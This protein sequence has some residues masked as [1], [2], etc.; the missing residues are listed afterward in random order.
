[1]TTSMGSG[2]IVDD[3]GLVITNAHVVGRKQTLKVSTKDGREF[4]ANV[5]A[6]DVNSD[7]ALVQV[8][9]ICYLAELICFSVPK[10]QK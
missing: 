10:Q 9:Q 2:F 8:R 6:V 7:L 3:T 5:L 4:D 1:M